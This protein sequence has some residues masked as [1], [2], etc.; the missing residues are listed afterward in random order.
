MRE[1]RLAIR[2]LWR[3]PGFSI[4]AI[5]TLALATGATTAMF[6]AVS[7][8][9]LGPIAIHEPERLVVGWLQDRSRHLEVVELSYR[10]FQEWAARSTSFTA[11]AAM[12]STTWPSVLDDSGDPMRVSSAGVSSSF[13]DA[14][15]VVPEIGRGFTPRDDEPGAPGVVVLS[16]RFWTSRFGG[17]RDIVG[18]TIKLGRPHEVVGVMPAALDFPR[19]TDYWTPVVPVIAASGGEWKAE[20]LEAVGVLFV[21]ARMRE[22]MTSALARDE[23]NRLVE[24]TDTGRSS[25]RVV[26]TP[27]IDFVLGPVRPALWALCAAVGILLLI[28]CANVS[29]LMMAR[30]SRGYAE[31]AIRA[32]L[33]ASRRRLGQRQALEIGVLSVAGAML[34]LVFAAWMVRAIVALAPDHVAGLSSMTL[35]YRIA[36]FSV[37]VVACV[38]LLCGLAPIRAACRVDLTQVLNETSRLTPSRQRARSALVVV[39]IALT[40]VLLVGAGLVARSFGNIRNVDIGFQPDRVL[41]M[42]V[43]PRLEKVAVNRW[44]DDLLARVSAFPGI[45]SAGAVYLRPLALGAIGQETGVIL[46]GQP[47]ED[48]SADRNPYLNYQIA[49]AG[50]FRA[51]RI[52]LVRGRLFDGGDRA[53]SERVVLVSESTARR[54]WPGRDAVGQRVLMATQA[55]DGSA[56]WRRVIGVVGDVRYRGIADGRLDVY[57]AP[58]QAVLAATD[59]VIRTS[60]DPLQMVSIVQAE[61]RRLDPGVLIDGVTTM[62]AVVTRAIAPWRL[63]A[64]LFTLFS[65]LAFVLATVGLL[66]LIALDVANR[67]RELAIRLA[68]G[69]APADLVRSVMASAGA[70]LAAGIA[71]GV[72]S[73]TVLSDGIRGLLFGVQP[74]DPATYAGVLALVVSVVL[75]SSYVPARRAGAIDPMTALRR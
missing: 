66:S 39:Q 22:G 71:I 62:D 32:A 45:E 26:L 40:V 6:S 28:G 31:Q 10:R 2:S 20:N 17:D 75:V 3:T 74:R 60:S 59:L 49:T 63:S 7:A 11:V 68:L 69:A 4:G 44:V 16:H 61:A 47:L 41:T 57:D 27:A 42:R 30:V 54:L 24:A 51:M 70:R 38:A 36:A 12:G 43:T 64:W 9:L 13:F 72:V 53:S 35:D 50:F 46:E 67:R 25:S 5:V 56:D 19:G 55:Q 15:G 52:P 58:M 48:A 14:L 23:L 37:V 73:A 1:L 33:G 29:S 65:G 34:G 8:V 21:V 18:K